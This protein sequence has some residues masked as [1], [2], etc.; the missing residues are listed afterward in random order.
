MK[1]LMP[2]M[3]AMLLLLA[4]C[5]EYDEELWLNSNGSGRAKLSLSIESHYSNTE[6]FLRVFS[7]PGIHLREYKLKNVG[8]KTKIY[9]VDFSFDNVDAFNNLDDQ[10]TALNFFG[11][12]SI[13]PK[14]ADGNIVVKRKISIEDR[15][16]F[17]QMGEQLNLG[18]DID[19]SEEA[20]IA[21]QDDDD[22][23]LLGILQDQ[24]E[25]STWT[26]KLHVPWKIIH[27]GDNFE[28]I[29]PNGKTVT[30]KFDTK[31]L[32]NKTELMTVVMK[33]GLSWLVYVLI[34]LGSLLFVFFIFW[35]V[36]IG[37]RS[38]LKDAIKHV[39]EREGK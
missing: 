24:Q 4:G 23:I 31:D 15:G 30:W 33:K 9:L 7:S 38:H 18:D 34:G 19:L 28:S 21:S 39:E 27:A 5:V 16:A 1:K 17:D 20:F 2:I 6:E 36:R 25:H 8:D 35:M 13:L 14:D 29:S 37:K 3:I 26:Y 32:I 22:D 12:L 11:Q 10:L